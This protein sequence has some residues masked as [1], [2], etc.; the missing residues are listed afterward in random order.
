MMTDTTHNS[1]VVG[2]T[3]D[4]HAEDA[5]WH[6]LIDERSAAEF[7]GITSRTMQAMRQRG[8]GPKYIR[9]SSRCLRYRRAD[10]AKWANDHICRSTADNGEDMG[11]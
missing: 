11:T 3:P 8:G 10:L 7:L 6:S 9:L 4:H 2:V 1:G 5:Y